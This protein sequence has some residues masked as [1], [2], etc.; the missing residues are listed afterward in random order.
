MINKLLHFIISLHIIEHMFLLRR[1]PTVRYLTD[2]EWQIASRFLFLSLALQ[3]I[4]R[5]IQQLE[6]QSPFKITEP[7]IELLLR[8][9]KQATKESHLLRKEMLKEKITITIINREDTFTTYLFR[10][11]G[12][13]EKRNYFNPAIRKKVENILHELFQTVKQECS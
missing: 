2:E 6:R 13:E 5:D 7:Y 12:K 10:C 11:K 8:V 3:V 9:E 1:V 4:K